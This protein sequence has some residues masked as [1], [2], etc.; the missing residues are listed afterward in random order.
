[1][2]SESPQTA[3]DVEG[4]WQEPEFDSGL[5]QRCRENWRVPVTDLSNA[6]LATFLRQ[7]LALKLVVPEAKRRIEADIHDDSELYDDE[8]EKAL[9]RVVNA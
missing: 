3:E 5:I 2:R 7:S 8:L 4:P 6:V 1:M 9:N